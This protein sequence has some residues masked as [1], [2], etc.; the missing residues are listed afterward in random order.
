ML[1]SVITPDDQLGMERMLEKELS[2]IDAEIIINNWDDGLKEAKGDFVCLLEKDS[3]VSEG[4]IAE[5][6]AVFTDKPAYRKLAMVSPK[7]DLPSY[8]SG[9]ITQPTWLS[10]NKG[11]TVNTG[12]RTG[13]NPTRIGMFLGAIIRTS[14]LKKANIPLD[15]D[16]I[17]VSNMLSIFFWDNGLRINLSADTMYEGS[18]TADYIRKLPFPLPIQAPDKVQD[19][20]E[21]EMIS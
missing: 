2:G 5:N 21:H 6:L 16:P 20:W 1:L 17:L 13:V 4:M 3:G 15:S 19:T 18:T 14:S 10:Y 9:G 11:L 12:Y 8:F 7:F